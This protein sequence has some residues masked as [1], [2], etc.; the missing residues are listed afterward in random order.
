MVV[1][2]DIGDAAATRRDVIQYS[3]IERFEESQHGSGRADLLQLGQL[4]GLDDLA[5]GD[6]ILHL[7][8]HKGDDG[9]RLADASRLG[10]HADLE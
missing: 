6:D 1:G 4:I 5:G 10:H 2:I 3:R 7:R 8:D 9:H